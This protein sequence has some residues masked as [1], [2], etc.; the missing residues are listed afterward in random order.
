MTMAWTPEREGN[1]LFH[2]HIM[3]HV[4]PERRLARLEPTTADAHAGHAN[5]GNGD[6]AMGMAGMII[7]VTIVKNTAATAPAPVGTAGR[8]VRRLMLNMASEGKGDDARFG[9]RLTGDGITM[10]ESSERISSPGPVLVLRR[11]EP[12]EITVVN[13]LGEATALHW[14][15][16]ELDSVYDGVHGWS[17]AGRNVAPMIQPAGSFVVRFTPPRTG[18]FIYHTHLHDQ[19]QL[20]LGLYGAMIVVD[21]GETFNPAADHVVILGRLGVDPAAPDVMIPVTPVVLNGELAPRYKWKAGQ[22]HRVRLINITPDDIL[23][24]GMETS[25][26]QASWTPVTKDGA[27][28]PDALRTAVPARQTIAVGETYDFELDVAPGP[29]NLWIDVRTTAGK[30]LAQGHVIVR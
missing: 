24:V 8:A 4:S 17:G 19:R 2:C 26:G 29:Q 9:F 16:M 14:H 13:H 22:R 18:T 11:G 12:V 27:P 28:L 1:W 7:G 15:G 21:D 20:P 30:W 5:H 25:R 3:H 10:T 6:P 23:S